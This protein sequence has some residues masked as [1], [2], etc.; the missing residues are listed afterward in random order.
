MGFSKM[1]VD[2][3]MK[4]GW[5]RGI[6][7]AFAAAML[8]LL[9]AG[10]AYAQKRVNEETYFKA[11][12]YPRSTAQSFLIYHVDTG[13]MVASLNDDYRGPVASLTKMM[14]CLIA[15][16]ELSWDAKYRL[17]YDEAKTLQLIKEPPRKGKTAPPPERPPE[18]ELPE[19]TLEQ[20][21]DLAMVPSNNTVCKI[22]AR[23][24]DGNETAF[25]ARM[26]KRAK[27][28]GMENTLYA[29]ASGL[30]SKA[31]QYSTPHDQLVL[32]LEV[33]G[34]PMLVQSI[35]KHYI[36]NIE[37]YDSTMYYLKAR[38]PIA[39]VKSGWTNAAGRCLVLLVEHPKF[40]SFILVMLKSSNIAQG[41]VDAEIILSRF[42]LIEVD[43]GSL[44]SAA[45]A[46]EE[47][48]KKLA[49]AKN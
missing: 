46:Q 42:G 26:T 2:V 4:F 11:N 35:R 12:L 43:G 41:F 34:R 37:R 29:N 8:A 40:G 28:L 47:E 1:K 18:D 22:L 9:I 49:A 48:R 38:Y 25:A 14:T 20:L 27:E 3:Y 39:G 36:H 13:R 16:E 45:N 44:L 33:L 30:P 5:F 23:L 19:V 7:A 24:I 21:V 17:T 10:A 32:T 6:C 31:P 15:D